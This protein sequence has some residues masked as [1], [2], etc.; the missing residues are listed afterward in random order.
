MYLCHHSGCLRPWGSCRFHHLILHVVLIVPSAVPSLLKLGL[1]TNGRTVIEP[2]YIGRI[3]TNPCG[4]NFGIRT[5]SCLVR[6]YQ[7]A[8]G[9]M[10]Y[11][12]SPNLFLNNFSAS[13]CVPLVL[14]FF[15]IARPHDD[16]RE[17]F[18][19]MQYGTQVVN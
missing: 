10:K 16:L 12:F 15:L 1:L 18:L 13:R 11:P 3:M 17:P 7:G 2:S 9:K 14:I 6:L 4:I 19:I 8:T 5:K